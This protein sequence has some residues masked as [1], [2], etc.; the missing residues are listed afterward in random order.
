MPNSL[1]IH[2]TVYGM[3]PAYREGGEAMRRRVPHQCNPHRPGSQAHAD[4]D[5]G[6][7]HEAA[8]EHLRFG[9]DL[10]TDKAR[11]K[12]FEM[13][14]EVP[15]DQHGEVDEDWAREARCKLGLEA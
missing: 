7:T 15:R 10:L 8:D 11:A 12:I 13:D 14:P 3:T 9:L 4:W 2:D 5:Y 1:V 6:H